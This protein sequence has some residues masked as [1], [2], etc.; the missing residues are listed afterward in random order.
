MSFS[1]VLDQGTCL[2]YRT[3]ETGFLGFC[4][5]E[6]SGSKDIFPKVIFTLVTSD[7]DEWYQYLIEREVKVHKIPQINPQFNIYH[8]M[9]KDPNGYIIEIQKF[10]DPG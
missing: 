1:L 10:L 2:I 8:F 6:V 9:L 5:R 4:H 3:S 7:V